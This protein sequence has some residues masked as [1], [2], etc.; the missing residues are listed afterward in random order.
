MS[1]LEGAFSQSLSV[2]RVLS[3]KGDESIKEPREKTAA[4]YKSCVLKAESRRPPAALIEALGG[5]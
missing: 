4:A 5:E 3:L 2:L 1:V